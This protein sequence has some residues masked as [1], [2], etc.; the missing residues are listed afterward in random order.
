M[1]NAHKGSKLIL[2][3]D[4]IPI[5][6]NSTHLDFN[7]DA[8]G[9]RLGSLIEPNYSTSI[10]TV[11]K[12]E[13]KFSNGVAIEEPSANLYN[14]AEGTATLGSDTANTT[15]VNNCT[16]Q[17]LFGNYSW[18]YTNISGNTFNMYVN[19]NGYYNNVTGT[20]FT[21]ST[22]A[23]RLDGK[24]ITTV[25]SAYIY[26]YTNGTFPVT[27]TSAN[28]GWY[29][30]QATGTFV[31]GGHVTLAGF[32]SLDGSTS[33]YFD[34][35]QV[36]NKGFATSY[37]GINGNRG[38][39]LLEYPC[40]PN[41]PNGTIGFWVKLD[42]SFPTSSYKIFIDSYGTSAGSSNS[43]RLYVAV[44]GSSLSWF[45]GNSSGQNSLSMTVTDF[46]SGYAFIVIKWDSTGR[47]LYFGKPDGSGLIQS[48]TTTQNFPTNWTDK[49]YI[50]NGTTYEYANAVFE[51]FCMWDRTLTDDEIQAIYTSNQPL[52]NPYDRR[53]YAL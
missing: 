34:G 12:G 50:G 42:E 32:N 35:F 43:N 28:N 3:D 31:S 45:E 25:G 41:P 16:E 49:M 51:D 53:A 19:G 48:A 30:L 21:L 23:K 11:R 1:S 26:A 36:E 46:H 27:I 4:V 22:Y 10:Y 15:R 7:K 20:T 40:I 37:M 47:T 24:P 9:I 44:N 5:G 39:G 52:Y 6:F 33:W 13:G 14:V 18:K 17:V 2:K 29:K 8:T 38:K